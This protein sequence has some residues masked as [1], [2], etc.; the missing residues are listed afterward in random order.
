MIGVL[1]HAIAKAPSFASASWQPHSCVY[2]SCPEGAVVLNASLHRACLNA[3]TLG[4]R[5]RRLR[6]IFGSDCAAILWLSTA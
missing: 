1:D 2:S 5:S 4:D 6:V 3:I